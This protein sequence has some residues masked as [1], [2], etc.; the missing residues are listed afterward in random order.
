MSEV[1]E[2]ITRWLWRFFPMVWLGWAVG[3]LIHWA[4]SVLEDEDHRAWLAEDKANCA[5]F[6]GWLAIAEQRLDELIVMR[7]M[8]RLGR[9]F[10]STRPLRHVPAPSVR[11]PQAA[12]ARLTRLVLRY[13][14]AE[15]LAAR[16]ALELQRLFEA[17]HFQL[18][19]IPHPV[20]AT[21]T[22]ILPLEAR[23]TT[24]TILSAALFPGE[25]HPA[26]PI[27]APPGPGFIS[28]KS[29]HLTPQASPLP[30]R[31]VAKAGARAR[32]HVCNEHE[33]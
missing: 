1:T 21:T 33:T 10:A 17:A 14:A 12:F 25:P 30:R 26:Q 18:E 19:A 29:A 3:H 23:S 9:S 27:R 24:T 5:W 8:G 32:D 13:H 15:R 22:T 28:S 31:S 11:T 20:E 7:A 4:V 2:I 16:R 6:G